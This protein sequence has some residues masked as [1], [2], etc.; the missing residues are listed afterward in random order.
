LQGDGAQVCYIAISVTCNSTVQ[1]AWR[2]KIEIVG[3]N[4]AQFMTA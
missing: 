1:C 3:I 2:L 4:G